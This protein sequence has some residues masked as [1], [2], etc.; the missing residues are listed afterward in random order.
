MLFSSISVD[1]KMN[2]SSS[3]KQILFACRLPGAVYR[4]RP[5]R[6]CQGL[7]KTC[8]NIRLHWSFL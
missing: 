4:I 6:P 1:L 2:A 7:G 8:F 5:R 3:L